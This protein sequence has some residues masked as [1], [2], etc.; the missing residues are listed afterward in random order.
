M[1]TFKFCSE[2]AGGEGMISATIE[3]S[4][5]RLFRKDSGWESFCLL[6]QLDWEEVLS[7]AVESSGRRLF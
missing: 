4:V 2:R 3:S 7:A 5:R 6:R 1:C